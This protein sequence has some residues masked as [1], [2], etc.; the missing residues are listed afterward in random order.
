MLEKVEEKPKLV[1]SRIEPV[2]VLIKPSKIKGKNFI[3]NNYQL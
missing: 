3:H 2:D 1:E